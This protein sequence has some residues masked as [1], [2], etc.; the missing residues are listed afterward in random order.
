MTRKSDKELEQERARQRLAEEQEER[1]KAALLHQAEEEAQR[2][3]TLSQ[4]DEESPTPIVVGVKPLRFD[5]D[6]LKI[7]EDYKKQFDKEPEQNGML[8]FPN[9]ESMDKFLNEQAAAG[10]KFFSVLVGPD[11][12]LTNHFEFSC[13]DGKRYS[14]SPEQI[15][16]Q[17]MQALETAGP[18]QDKV[19]SG[20]DMINKHIQN[21]KPN[22]SQAAKKA[23]QDITHPTEEKPK[24]NSPSPLSTEPKPKGY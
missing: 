2:H 9:Q 24:Y 21:T 1:E 6:W 15:R 4:P 10:R 17:L 11:G 3:R 19:Q 7:A 8:V 5:E 13:G 18:N 16:D 12:K 20:L 14:G 22:P 23:L